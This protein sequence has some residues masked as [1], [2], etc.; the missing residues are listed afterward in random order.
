MTKTKRLIR[1]GRILSAANG[2]TTGEGSEIIRH[3]T[4]QGFL[5]KQSS[6][7]SSEIYPVCPISLQPIF[8]QA[9]PSCLPSVSLSACMH[10]HTCVS[11]FLSV[12]LSAWPII[13]LPNCL[14]VHLSNSFDSRSVCHCVYLSVR[15]Y[16]CLHV[17]I[18]VLQSAWMWISD[19][20]TKYWKL[21]G[22]PFKF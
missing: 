14:Q 8:L 19:S 15:L 12:C 22:S 21:K 2:Q 5:R 10:L 6:S 16:V 1:S 18:P 7:S 11:V 3:S 9:R 17:C 20:Q 13:R 4:S